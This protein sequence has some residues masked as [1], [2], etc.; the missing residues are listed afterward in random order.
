MGESTRS[1]NEETNQQ[2]PSEVEEPTKSL[3]EDTKET[4]KEDDMVDRETA[5]SGKRK[6]HKSTKNDRQI[7]NRPLDA[8]YGL[9]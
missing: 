6:K 5:S 4:P 3:N 2:P 7:V 9:F 8:V 1:L